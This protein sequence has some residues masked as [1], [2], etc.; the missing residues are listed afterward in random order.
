MS[1]KKYAVLQPQVIKELVKER[2]GQKLTKVVY[3]LKGNVFD[4]FVIQ[5]ILG[6]TTYIVSQLSSDTAKKYVELQRAVDYISKEFK[7]RKISVELTK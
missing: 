1:R 5:V 3:K 7:T 2:S 6:N 4:G